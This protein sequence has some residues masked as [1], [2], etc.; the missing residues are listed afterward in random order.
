MRRKNPLVTLIM[1]AAFI[2]AFATPAPS[3]QPP[4]YDLRIERQSLSSALQE[5]AKQSGVQIIFFSRVTD[6]HEVAP[7]SGKFTAVAALARLLNDAPDLAFRELN[8]NTIEVLPKQAVNR[9]DGAYASS[10]RSGDTGDGVLT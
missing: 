5:F 1:A 10:T 2:P 8:S 6:G 7:L 9:L 4:Q 3:G